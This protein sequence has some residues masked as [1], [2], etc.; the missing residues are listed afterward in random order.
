[1]KA[2]VF[3]F[4]AILLTCFVGISQAN[5]QAEVTKGDGYFYVDYE[6]GGETIWAIVKL[7]YHTVITPSGNGLEV[8]QGVIVG[9]WDPD[10]GNIWGEMPPLSKSAIV[11]E[12]VFEIWQWKQVITPNGHVTITYKTKKQL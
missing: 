9:Y 10:Y 5:A 12:G 1:M 4:V 8:Y 2:K 3:L 6:L 7:D 11:S